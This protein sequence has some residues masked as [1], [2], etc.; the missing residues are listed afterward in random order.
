[1]SNRSVLFVFVFFVG[2]LAAGCSSETSSD[3]SDLTEVADTAE[4]ADVSEVTDQPDTVSQADVSDQSTQSDESEPSDVTVLQDQSH[5]S[6]GTAYDRVVIPDEDIWSSDQD[7]AVDID[8]VLPGCTI[9]TDFL[10]PFEGKPSQAAF[11]FS[12]V[13][14][15]AASSQII[16]GEGQIN[17]TYKGENI[18]AGS[19]Y[20][21]AYFMYGNGSTV[22]HRVV[23][24]WLGY[25]DKEK[26]YVYY[27]EAKLGL[28]DIADAAAAKT[29]IIT[30]ADSSTD[31]TL[32]VYK[33]W[34][35]PSGDLIKLCLQGVP[36]GQDNE[37]AFYVCDTSYTYP[38]FLDEK[39]DSITFAG[40]LVLF[41]DTEVLKKNNNMLC[42]CSNGAG[43]WRNCDE[44][45]PD[46]YGLMR[47]KLAATPEGSG[48]YRG[49]LY[50]EAK[51]F[52][53]GKIDTAYAQ[54]H[55]EGIW[56]DYNYALPPFSGGLNIAGFSDEMGE[57][58]FGFGITIPP[59]GYKTIALLSKMNDTGKILLRQQSF[60]Q[61][62]SKPSHLWINAYLPIPAAL[63]NI[64]FGS[65]SGKIQ[66]F[67]Y[68]AKVQC[69]LAIAC[70]GEVT[71]TK[72]EKLAQSEGGVLEFSS[73]LVDNSRYGI[74][75]YYPGD[76]TTEC[77]YEQYSLDAGLDSPAEICP[78]E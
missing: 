25:A 6:D 39:E 58:L 2:V 7:A 11:V 4:T 61:D 49:Y 45:V 74:A 31:T 33:G 52:H 16:E 29:H 26:G 3:L 70:G 20:Q 48:T 78:K 30:M 76:L 36:T 47:A 67:V 22:D 51:L 24:K 13:I 1:M 59:K 75:L 12:G 18:D 43:A 54:K 28:T 44:G 71:I 63:G 55:P 41:D 46:S 65:G 56:Q 77:N 17:V 35:S 37:G 68:D 8:P 66:A 5:Q 19:E 73:P 23:T 21:R 53:D 57:R 10:K 34:T 14:Q 32:K 60:F 72:A 62:E 27:V 42:V 40:N 15:D 64:A 50:D 69:V 9:P 38:D